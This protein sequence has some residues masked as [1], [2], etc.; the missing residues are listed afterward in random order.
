MVLHADFQTRPGSHGL[1]LREGLHVLRSGN[2]SLEAMPLLQVQCGRAGGLPFDYLMTDIFSG[3]LPIAKVCYGDCSAAEHWIRRGYDFG[4]RQLNH[5][6]E[7]I[8]RSSI[9]QLPRSQRWLRQGWASD[10]SLSTVGWQR[11]REA[12]EVLSEFDIALLIITKVWSPP[13]K[14]VL[15]RLGE[16]GA[17]LRVSL[18][19]LDTRQQMEQRVRTLELYRS[20]GGLAVPYLMSC[21]YRDDEL[22]RNEAA[23]V[24]Y[25]TQ[26]QLI[27]AEHPLRISKDSD[28]HPLMAEGG[29]KHP[30]FPH[31]KWFGRIYDQHGSFI[32]P[33]PTFL[34]P[35]YRVRARSLIEL[36][37]DDLAGVSG[38]LPSH[39][40]L[41]QQAQYQ[42]RVFQH[43]TYRLQEEAYA[44]RTSSE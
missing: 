1:Q 21:Y 43:G 9:R 7:P 24:D 8:F 14:D 44:P 42:A 27:A 30:K 38:N 33:P 22:N 18:S 25:V 28:L 37:A 41:E 29:F 10:C 6:S 31:Q 16:L 11:I 2:V 15:S 23:L 40:E 32:L 4:K 26:S 3:C 19:A 5:F 20:L 12:A 39:T 36:S 13:P 34:L 17:E 35:E